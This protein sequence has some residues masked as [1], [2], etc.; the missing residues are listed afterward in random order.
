MVLKGLV[1]EY[2]GLAIEFEMA[3][4]IDVIQERPYSWNYKLILDQVNISGNHY[5]SWSCGVKVVLRTL[6]GSGEPSQ[7]L[8]YF[9]Y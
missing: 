8:V 5:K 3:T 1:M 9:V 6:S 2:F 4:L 7:S